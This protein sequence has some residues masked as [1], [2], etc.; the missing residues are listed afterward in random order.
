M[1]AIVQSSLPEALDLPAVSSNQCYLQLPE[2]ISFGSGV[3]D[4][5]LKNSR[6]PVLNN[7]P[8]QLWWLCS[9]GDGEVCC[10]LR[11][12]PSAVI[13]SDSHLVDIH[14]VLSPNIPG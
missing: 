10:F 14:P 1:S 13:W 12:P 8:S 7:Y 3:Y 2:D 11:V 9:V 5:S 6:L 4:T